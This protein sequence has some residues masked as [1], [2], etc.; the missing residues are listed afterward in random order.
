MIIGFEIILPPT[1]KPIFFLTAIETSTSL[2]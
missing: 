1:L 2:P